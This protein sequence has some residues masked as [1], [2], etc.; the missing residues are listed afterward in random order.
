M[1]LLDSDLEEF[2]IELEAMMADTWREHALCATTGDRRIW[3]DD[4]P[5][6]AEG[7]RLS[8]LA[9]AICEACPVRIECLDNAMA[10]EDEGIRSGLNEKQRNVIYRHR[11][12]YRAYFNYDM[13][14]IPADPEVETRETIEACGMLRV[15]D[16]SW[17]SGATRPWESVVLW[18]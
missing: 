5:S 6:D 9:S 12:K 16:G 11:V 4:L 13:R 1:T 17:R 8:D 7:P 2:L 15:R 14:A 3:F 18:N 10:H